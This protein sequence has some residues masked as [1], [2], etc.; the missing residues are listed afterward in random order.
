MTSLL[1]LR[2][3]YVILDPGKTLA[4]SRDLMAEL[5]EPG[6]DFIAFADGARHTV[7]VH[8]PRFERE[9]RLGRD[10]VPP[11]AVNVVVDRFD[12]ATRTSEQRPRAFGRKAVALRS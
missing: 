5:C 3:Q 2:M 11:V 12:P 7:A 9:N 1:S 10:A 6:P 4:H 8:L